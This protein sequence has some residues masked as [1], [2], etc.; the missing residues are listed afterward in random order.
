MDFALFLP[1]AI[2]LHRVT[3]YCFVRPHYTVRPHLHRANVKPQC[4][5]QHTA[6]AVRPVCA[7]C[8]HLSAQGGRLTSKMRSARASAPTSS[9][10]PNTRLVLPSSSLKS[11]VY[12]IECTVCCRRDEVGFNY[13]SWESE[14]SATTVGETETVLRFQVLDLDSHEVCA[15]TKT[16]H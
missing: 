6:G 4:C 7:Q 13:L 3:A 11:G 2:T 9:F 16:R 1:C 10:I 5:A 15:T 12:G 8:A 14:N